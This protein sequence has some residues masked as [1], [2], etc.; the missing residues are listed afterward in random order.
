M[1]ARL[2]YFPKLVYLL[3]RHRNPSGHKIGLK[4]LGMMARM[5]FRPHWLRP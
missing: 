1:I 3:I 4:E 2:T 5:E